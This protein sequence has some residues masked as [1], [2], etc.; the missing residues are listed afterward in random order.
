[1]TA[2]PSPLRLRRVVAMIGAPN[3]IHT[4]GLGAREQHRRER[5]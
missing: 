4:H 1:M 2:G 3:P 5:D